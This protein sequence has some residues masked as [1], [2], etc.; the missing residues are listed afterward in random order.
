MPKLHANLKISAGRG[1]P[2]R[3][4]LATAPTT[5]AIGVPVVVCQGTYTTPTGTTEAALE[6]MAGKKSVTG[7]T[8]FKTAEALAN[9]AA[10]FMAMKLVA[11][12]EMGESYGGSSSKSGP[13]YAAGAKDPRQTLKNIREGSKFWHT[14]MEQLAD[15]L[16]NELE[17]IPSPSPR[18]LWRLKRLFL[19]GGVVLTWISIVL[20]L[21]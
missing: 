1:K 5:P 12:D 16:Q 18:A 21:L 2:P 20:F 3:S 17:V 7:P 9:D 13:D 11:G 15:M 10:R 19:A 8:T 4:S 6:K 14:H